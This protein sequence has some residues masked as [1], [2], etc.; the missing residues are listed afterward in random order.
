[1]GDCA[2]LGEIGGGPS[3][4][5]P[6]VSRT[7][8]DGSW[9]AARVEH[10]PLPRRV[11][12]RDREPFWR[13][14]ILGP[15]EPS[16]LPASSARPVYL[17]FA[18]SETSYAQEHEAMS[19]ALRTYHDNPIV[20]SDPGAASRVGAE[21]DHGASLLRR[22]EPS[23]AGDARPRCECRCVTGRRCSLLEPNTMPAAAQETKS[24]SLLGAS[25]IRLPVSASDGNAWV[26]S[27]ND[28]SYVGPAGAASAADAISGVGGAGP[29][30]VAGGRGDSAST[31][32]QT[33][34]PVLP[35]VARAR[36][37]RDRGERGEP[38]V[39]SPSGR[40]RRTSG[41][42]PAPA[43]INSGLTTAPS[44]RPP[45]PSAPAPP[46]SAWRPSVDHWP[47]RPVLLGS[48]EL[49]A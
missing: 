10:V 28:A 18:S 13:S 43:S 33:V 47:A 25:P 9:G 36:G 20:R 7:G 11:R 32:S 5:H 29:D 39:G 27:T 38:E 12:Q 45:A 41:L 23:V 37:R 17:L 15:G 2:D 4:V 30:T 42:A 34:D 48:G 22:A 26:G 21:P 49:H 19:V 40:G 31:R 46:R 35:R 3:H 14:Q 44:A 16:P 6:Y 24:V 1:M 8:A